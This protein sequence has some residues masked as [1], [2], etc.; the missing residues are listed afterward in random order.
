MIPQ[1][2][3]LPVEDEVRREMRAK[4]LMTYLASLDPRKPW[5]VLVRPF[6]R[7]RSNQQN[8]YERGVAC[9]LLSEATGYEADEIHEYLCGT[10]FGWRQL[11][12][13]KTPNNP[14]GIR[15][16]PRR[17]TTLNDL[18]E[19]DVLSKSD[20]ADFIAFVQRFGA[21]HGVFI[22]DPDPDFALKDKAA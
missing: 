6:K 8:R 1:R 7:T 3:M 16:V 2:I 15:D 10:Y 18:G 19:R 14:K 20:Y 12:C 5:E 17:T 21:K 11:A 9:K 22:P 4:R 13:P